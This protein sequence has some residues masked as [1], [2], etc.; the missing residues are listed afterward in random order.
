MCRYIFLLQKNNIDLKGAIDTSQ[1]AT[2][3]CSFDPTNLHLV[4]STISKLYLSKNL[5]GIE[6]GRTEV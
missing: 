1:Y 5:G 4:T 6:H 2:K 3:S